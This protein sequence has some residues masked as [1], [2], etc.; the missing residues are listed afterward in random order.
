MIQGGNGQCNHNNPANSKPR[1]HICTRPVLAII[2]SKSP[3]PG[4]CRGCGQVFCRSCGV[5]YLCRNCMNRLPEHNKRTLINECERYKKTIGGSI[6]LRVAGSLMALYSGSYLQSGITMLRY[7]DAGYHSPAIAAYV[8]LP[9]IFLAIGVFL[10]LSSFV[11]LIHAMASMRAAVIANCDP[12]HGAS[13]T[14]PVE[15]PLTGP[16]LKIMLNS[17]TRNYP[18]PDASL[19]CTNCGRILDRIQG[20]QYCMSCGKKLIEH[21]NLAKYCTH[22]GISLPEIEDR[23]FCP[24]CGTKIASIS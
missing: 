10:F 7:S 14:S 15:R 11:M 8:V 23:Q 21:K 16:L 13:K 18:A 22:C 4:V 12:S 2:T 1:C 3:A 24:V 6:A 19:R 5:P 9:S 20:M 17:P